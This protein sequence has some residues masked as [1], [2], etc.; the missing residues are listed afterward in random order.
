MAIF[1][2]SKVNTYINVHYN[3]IILIKICIFYNYYHRAPI[4]ERINISQIATI[5]NDDGINCI[6]NTIIAVKYKKE[7]DFLTSYF[8]HN[9]NLTSRCKKPFF[10]KIE[11]RG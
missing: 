11:N 10:S 4:Y 5:Q 3:V 9:F 1:L 7:K 2:P 8:R 6:G